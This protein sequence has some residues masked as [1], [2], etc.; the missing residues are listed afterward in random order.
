MTTQPL[1]YGGLPHT[2]LGISKFYGH[3]IGVDDLRAINNVKF[4]NW[5]VE[6]ALSPLLK[7]GFIVTVEE[8]GTTWQV[9]KGCKWV[10]TKQGIN[11]LY[12]MARPSKNHNDD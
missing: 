3:A 5:K 10:V 4:P 8:A 9:A 6:R 1:Q 12:S 7:N 2:I 11:A